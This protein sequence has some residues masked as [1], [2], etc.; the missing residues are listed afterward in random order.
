MESRL[1]EKIEASRMERIKKLEQELEKEKE[2]G[3]VLQLEIDQKTQEQEAD[4]MMRLEQ[5]G[6]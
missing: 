6:K 3:R 4:V 2:R 5:L 1:I